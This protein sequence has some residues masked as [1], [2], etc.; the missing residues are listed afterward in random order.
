MTPDR[1]LTVLML[2]TVNH[3]HVEHLALGM[4]ERGH[5]VIVGGNVESSM[6]ESVLPRAGIELRPGP[7]GLRRR[8]SG[9]V[10]HVRWIRTL[11]RELR[12]DVVHAHWMPGFAFFAALARARPLVAMAWGSDVLRANRVRLAAGRYAIRRAALVMSDSDALMARLEELGAARERTFLVNWGVDLETFAPP[13]DGRAAVRARLGLAEGP[14]V[15]SPRSLMPVYNVPMILE[16]FDRAGARLPDLRLVVKHMGPEAEKLGAFPHAD[17][18][19]LVG[20]VAYE[21][22]ADYYRAAEVCVSLAS[23]D[24]SPRSVWEAM[25]CGCALVVSDLP[26]VHE[27]IEH[28]RHALVVPIE[29]G[30]VADAIE[31]LVT[32]PGLATRLGGNA[33]RL[34]EEHRD[35]DREMTRL[36]DAYVRL[37][38]G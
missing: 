37:A 8:L 26:W 23:S 16:A 18:V 33:R 24:S 2:G 10:G 34:V 30:A 9:V 19:E 35:R 28:E 27:L 3:P 25:A 14:T 7:T 5:R 29:P 20:H 38:E 21:A 12:P 15:I 31:R 17:R 1:T 13:P 32:D 4:A 36:S 6:P 11:L 22:M